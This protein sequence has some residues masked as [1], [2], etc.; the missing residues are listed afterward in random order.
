MVL[1]SGYSKADQPKK[2]NNIQPDQPRFLTKDNVERVKIKRIM[3]DGQES[4]PV[5]LCLFGFSLT[6]STTFQL[7]FN[8]AIHKDPCP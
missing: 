3:F 5:S 6:I 2:A 8:I 7:L 1:Q 4:E